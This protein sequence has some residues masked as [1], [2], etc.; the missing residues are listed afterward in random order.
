MGHGVGAT[1]DLL[2]FTEGM[3]RVVAL[4]ERSGGE[5]T[6]LTAAGRNTVT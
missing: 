1:P 2:A 3:Q 4:V 5:V 6:I